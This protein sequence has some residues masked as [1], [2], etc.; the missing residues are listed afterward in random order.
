[1][2]LTFFYGRKLGRGSSDHNDYGN[3]WKYSSIIIM[4]VPYDSVNLSPGIQLAEL[5]YAWHDF[6]VILFGL[7]Y[8]IHGI[9]LISLHFF[10]IKHF[11]SKLA[12]GAA[13]HWAKD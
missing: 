11:S 7:F 1:M 5:K 13:E 6:F 4:D 12:R 9:A 3:D 2:L 10:T 8:K